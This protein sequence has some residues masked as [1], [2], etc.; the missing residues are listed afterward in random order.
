[1]I[2]MKP[3]E[4][5]E[6]LMVRDMPELTDEQRADLRARLARDYLTAQALRTA[7]AARDAL[8]RKLQHAA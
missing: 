2:I 8:K 5:L 1:M 7:I 6:K 4:A 3:N